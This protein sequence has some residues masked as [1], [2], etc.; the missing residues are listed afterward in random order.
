MKLVGI[1]LFDN[2]EV[3]DFAGPFEVFSLAGLTVEDS[4][5]ASGSRNYGFIRYLTG[6]EI[7]FLLIILL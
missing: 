3:L 1:F 4:Y 5:K 2:V 6:T 7:E